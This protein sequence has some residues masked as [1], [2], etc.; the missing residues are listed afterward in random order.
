M[1]LQLIRKIKSA[2]STVGELTVNGVK[3]CFILEDV[4]R[5][6]TQDMPLTEL[7]SKK[8]FGQ[9]AI[10][11]GRYEVTITFSNRFQRL[12]PLL[13]NVPGFTGIR[14]HPGNS[15][16]DTDGCLLPG[17]HAGENWVYDSRIAFKKLCD[18]IQQ[19]FD[20]QEKIFIT[21]N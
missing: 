17:T 20:R 14:M 3:A 11:T 8:V 9:T 18:V 16:A 13:L 7:Q 6:L 15:A 12:L 21:L 19:A 2:K 10:P 1:E 4:D 5:G